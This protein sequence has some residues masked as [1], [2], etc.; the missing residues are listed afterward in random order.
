MESKKIGIVVM[1]KMD[2][3]GGAPRVVVDL[4]KSLNE[5]GYEVQILT[6]W[7]LDYE[8]ISEIFEPIKIEK[9]YN[10][11]SWGRKFAIGRNISRKLMKGQFN[12]MVEDVDL[13]IDVDGGVLDNYLP[14]NKRYII[15]RISGIESDSGGWENRSLKQKMKSFIKKIIED[16]EVLPSDR[17][18]YAV[19]DWTRRGLIE[20]WNLQPAELCLYP[21]IKTDHF[22]YKKIKKDQIIILGRISPNKRL[23]ES[24]RVFA[25][26]AKNSDYKLIVLGGA[27]SDSGEYISYLKSVA[28][29]EEI[30]DK[31]E[32]V[33]NPSFEKLKSIVEE[34]KILIECQRNISLTMTSIE[35]LAAGVIVLVHRNGGTY[36]EVLDNG[37]YGV[38]FESIDEG[39]ERLEKIIG[40][41]GEKKINVGKLVDRSRFFSGDNFRERLGEILVTN[42]L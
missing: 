41:L 2:N 14:K 28:E 3:G 6:P 22:S 25:K 39:A 29:E 37:K 18:I 31:I 34:S 8:K 10:L 24:I 38:G 35:C 17:D 27:T 11:S 15:W 13:V 4:I 20:E 21:E 5:F 12:K 19:D 40:N 42:G 30:L 7:K 23:D 26:G 36:R 33:V 9:E 1:F 32:F 16:R